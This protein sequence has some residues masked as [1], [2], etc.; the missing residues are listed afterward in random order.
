MGICQYQ[1]PDK[2]DVGIFKKIAIRR[3]APVEDRFRETGEKDMRY[4][5]K[6]NKMLNVEKF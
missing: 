4:D 1:R 2:S 5:F 3:Q 6:K